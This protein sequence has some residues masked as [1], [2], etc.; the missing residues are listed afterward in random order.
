MPFRLR[1][2]PAAPISLRRGGAA[3]PMGRYVTPRNGGERGEGGA[4]PAMEPCLSIFGT[5]FF[6]FKC[7]ED[8]PRDLLGPQPRYLRQRGAI[9][10][11]SQDFF[12]PNY[13][14]NK[15]AP[16]RRGG[17]HRTGGR[18][19]FRIRNRCKKRGKKSLFFGHRAS[20]LSYSRAARISILNRP[21]GGGEGSLSSAPPP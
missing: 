19:L 21:F 14:A 18:R 7:G 9:P 3:W 4:R 5:C 1:P 6:P 15:V 2:R 12:V 13:G 8:V 11:T 10:R 16:R 17:G 20:R